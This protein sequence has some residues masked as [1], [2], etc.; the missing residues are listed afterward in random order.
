MGGVTNAPSTCFCFGGV[1]TKHSAGT[2]FR[3]F[4]NAR[5]FGRFASRLARKGAG[6][7]KI[8]LLVY[9]GI[10]PAA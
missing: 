4:P 6:I 10:N 7:D 1:H 8:P 3:Y 5:L 9:Y 2:F